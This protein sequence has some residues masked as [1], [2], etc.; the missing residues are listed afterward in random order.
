MS[1]ITIWL[2]SRT[3]LVLQVRYSASRRVSEDSNISWINE[4]MPLKM[5]HSATSHRNYHTIK[6]DV[7]NHSPRAVYT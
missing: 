2:F 1:D 6:P 4:T 3:Y 7:I 5:Q